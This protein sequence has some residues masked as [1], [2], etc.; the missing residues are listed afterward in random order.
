LTTLGNAFPL[1]AVE[2]GGYGVRSARG[3]I[4]SGAPAGERVAVQS[5]RK[6]R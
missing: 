3:K 1:L 5:V 4:P 6:D 2:E